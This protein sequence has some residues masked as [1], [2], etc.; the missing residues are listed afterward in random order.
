MVHRVSMLNMHGAGGTN[1]CLGT[2]KA[3]WVN[4]RSGNAS[5]HR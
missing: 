2:V 3:I 4:W 1:K 5:V